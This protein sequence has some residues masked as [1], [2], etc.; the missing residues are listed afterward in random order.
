ML[1]NSLRRDLW[2][3]KRQASK[4]RWITL[5][6]LAGVPAAWLRQ[7]SPGDAMPVSGL[8]FALSGALL[9]GSATAWLM[10]AYFLARSARRR[11]EPVETLRLVSRASLAKEWAFTALGCYGSWH[12]LQFVTAL[13]L[14]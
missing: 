9:A 7:L 2:S 10:S 6:L 4:D 1:R 13:F 3:L 14:G 12:V 8:L 11:R 5:A